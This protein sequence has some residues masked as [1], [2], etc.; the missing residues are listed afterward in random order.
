M[1]KTLSALWNEKTICFIFNGMSTVLFAVLFYYCLGLTGENSGG[2]EDEHIYF[3][4]DSVLLNSLLIAAALKLLQLGG[5]LADKWLKSTRRRNIFLGTVCALTGM[6]SLYWIFACK[7]EP[8]ADQGIIC[9][10]ASD[11]NK[12]DFSGL[13]KGGY[14]AY[15]PQQLGMVTLLRGIYLLFGDNNY[16]AFRVLVALLIPVLVLSGCKIVRILTRDNVRAEFYYLLFMLCCFPMYAYVN[17]VYSD[18]IA[19]VSGFFGIWMYLSC[20]REFS[21]GRLC[22]FGFSMGLT[23][24][25]RKNFLILIIAVAIVILVKL[26]FRHDRKNIY[27]GAALLAGI[28]VMNLAL[29]LGYRDVRDKEAH[30]IPALLFVVMGLNDDYGHAGWWNNY[31]YSTFSEV[32]SDVESARKKAWEDLQSYGQLYKN[33]P[34]YM[35]DFFV[36]KINAQWNAPMYQSIAMNDAVADVL[37]PPA[38]NIYEGGFLG[39][40]L[41]SGMKIYQLLMYGSILFLLLSER[42]GINRME[43]YLLLVAVFGGF[44]FSLIWE[45]K[46]RYILPFFFMQIPYMAMGINHIM[47]Y[48]EEKRDKMGKK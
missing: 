13:A 18:L 5:K 38:D 41:E 46:T 30:G 27:M 2:L 8:I 47:V 15:Y 24:V 4:R 40:V 1:K 11:F 32:D 16:Q 37:L 22:A 19:T 3:K 29:W 42:K 33:D 25:L 43:F 26:L 45:A 34:D 7:T 44:L 39:K 9:Q 35:I 6:I 31:G 28:A 48:A 23:L 12:G 14:M 10:Y 20:S 17:F 36:R 21:W